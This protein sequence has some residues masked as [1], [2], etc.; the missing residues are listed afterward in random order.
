MTQKEVG[1]TRLSVGFFVTGRKNTND[2]LYLL[3]PSWGRYSYP[4]SRRIFKWYLVYV[5]V[6][7]KGDQQQIDG[8]IIQV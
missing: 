2:V 6:A 3:V 8:G 5:R 7:M 4:F 1:V